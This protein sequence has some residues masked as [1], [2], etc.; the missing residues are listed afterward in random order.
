[1]S[2]EAICRHL[3]IW[4]SQIWTDPSSS[5]RYGVG[6]GL[7]RY[8]HNTSTPLLSKLQKCCAARVVRLSAG[9]E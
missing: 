1:M 6:P 8:Q 3:G 9:M 7:M 4:K 2:G 5:S